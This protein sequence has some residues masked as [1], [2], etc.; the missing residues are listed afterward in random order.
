M[1]INLYLFYINF[2]IF[3]N[4]NLNCREK[5]NKNCYKK[6]DFN[7]NNNENDD[8]N[9]NDKKKD[10]E[11]NNKNSDEIFEKCLNFKNNDFN[12]PKQYKPINSGFEWKNN[13]CWLISYIELYLND[14][15]N[16]EFLR[17]TNFD[18]NNEDDR[19]YIV[20][21]DILKL[22]SNDE[23]NY[24]LDFTKYNDFFWSEL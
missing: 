8:N 2:I 13:N 16:Q 11:D 21:R 6:N 1:N 20:L 12:F 22:L 5:Y 24:K 23:G 7:K 17:N 3:N 14:P 19:K 10:K 15:K 4:L 9:E 18:K